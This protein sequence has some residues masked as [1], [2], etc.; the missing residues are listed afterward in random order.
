MAKLRF[1]GM[2]AKHVKIGD[3][4]VPIGPGDFI[5]LSAADEK[6]EDNAELMNELIPVPSKAKGGEE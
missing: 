4:S 2:Y 1:V 5:E 6:H 3:K